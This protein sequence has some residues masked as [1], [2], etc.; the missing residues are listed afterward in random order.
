MYSWILE[1]KPSRVSIGTFRRYYNA[2]LCVGLATDDPARSLEHDSE[3]MECLLANYINK[4]C[5]A[6]SL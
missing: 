1:G 6:L 2:A 5:L 3:E 4:V